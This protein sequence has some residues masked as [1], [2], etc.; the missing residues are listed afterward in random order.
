MV[1]L[2]SASLKC[3]LHLQFAWKPLNI[4]IKNSRYV[5]NVRWGPDNA[6]THLQQVSMKQ[7]QFDSLPVAMFTYKV[8]K[9]C[10]L[11]AK[12]FYVMKTDMHKQLLNSI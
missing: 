8:T 4:K 11:R 7:Y 9:V 1:Y 2:N 3:H 6:V 12:G 10:Y 5:Q